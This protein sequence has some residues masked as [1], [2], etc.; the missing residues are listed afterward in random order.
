LTDIS[1]PI[2]SRYFEF[3]NREQASNNLVQIIQDYRNIINSN[4]EKYAHLE[5]TEKDKS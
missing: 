3:E 5:D 4:E 2:T 1:G